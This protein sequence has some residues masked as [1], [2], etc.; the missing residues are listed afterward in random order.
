MIFE[1]HETYQTKKEFSAII[2]EGS[3]EEFKEGIRK[4][5]PRSKEEA[6]EAV[7]MF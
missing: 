3:L 1:F 5:L 4:S 2:Q 6:D 7:E